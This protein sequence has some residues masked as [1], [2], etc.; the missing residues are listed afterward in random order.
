MPDSRRP[1]SS[2]VAAYLNSRVGQAENLRLLSNRSP[3]VWHHHRTYRLSIVGV[4]DGTAFFLV[5]AKDSQDRA[6]RPVLRLGVVAV[7]LMTDLEGMLRVACLNADTEFVESAVANGAKF[8]GVV[9]S[10]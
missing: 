4:E 10:D 9:D 2:L 8:E 6:T 5:S 1:S 3:A 7:T